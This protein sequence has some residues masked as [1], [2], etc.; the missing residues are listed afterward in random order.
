M[1][2]ESKNQT[3]T[4][5]NTL[6]NE[7]SGAGI[8]FILVGGLATVIQGAPI[9]TFDVD[10][11]HS[12]TPENI[13]KLITFLRS[14]DAIHR[15]P[16]D[17][18][19]APRERDI[20][21]KGHALFSTSLGPLDV[22]AFIEGGRNYDDLLEFVIEI[23]F[24]GHVIRVLE[25]KKIVEIKRESNHLRDKQRLPVLEETLKQI[26]QSKLTDSSETLSKI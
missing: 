26:E 8:D 22:L 11:V 5:L 2:S 4:D 13:S 19:L 23:E 7:L 16:D 6:L 24:Q 10:I 9:T 17:K 20:S 3:K 25:L 12:Q 21:G 1:P 18:K 15:R 14:L